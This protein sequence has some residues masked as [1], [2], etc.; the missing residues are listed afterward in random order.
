[1]FWFNL[2]NNTVVF[3]QGMRN[4]PCKRGL[5][6]HPCLNR[7]F[8]KLYRVRL[9]H[10][11]KCDPC[12]TLVFPLDQD[13]PAYC[14]L[15]TLSCPRSSGYKSSL[16]E[17]LLTVCPVV[18]NLVEQYM[19]VSFVVYLRE[20]IPSDRVR[21][22]RSS[23]SILL[24]TFVCQGLDNRELSRGGG[25]IS[26][27]SS[28]GISWI[29][30][31]LFLFRIRVWQVSISLLVLQSD[32]IVSVENTLSYRWMISPFVHSVRSNLAKPRF[33]RSFRVSNYSQWHH[34]TTIDFSS[35]P[36]RYVADSVSGLKN[37]QSYQQSC[38]IDM[39]GLSTRCIT[40]QKS[41]MIVRANHSPYH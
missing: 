11:F 2:R 40:Q 35:W 30:I 18:N 6:W 31:V 12:R 23:M 10:V 9:L 16:L 1:M 36:F 41:E 32:M 33:G 3:P 14:G 27:A 34:M 15:A 37:E 20:E 39:V 28:T 24:R 25:W 4:P 26:A 22:Q 7:I 21:R 8:S 29:S 38:R 19:S 5:L 13:L 17:K